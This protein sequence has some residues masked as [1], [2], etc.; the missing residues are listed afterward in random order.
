MWS[1]AVMVR[2][3]KQKG[4]SSDDQASKKLRTL[5]P[6]V[7]GGIKSKGLGR[8]EKRKNWKKEY[9]TFSKI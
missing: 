6:P 9:R 5:P 4:R 2:L 7:G 3:I 1:G 8:E